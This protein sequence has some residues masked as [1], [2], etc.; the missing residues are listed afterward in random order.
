MRQRPTTSAFPT[1]LDTTLRRL[2]HYTLHPPTT[3]NN[4]AELTIMAAFSQPTQTII[5]ALAQLRQTIGPIVS[6]VLVLGVFVAAACSILLAA[7][8]YRST[9][10]ARITFPKVS[11]K[12]VEG[13]HV[14]LAPEKFPTTLPSGVP[15]V[16]LAGSIEMNV[17]A[18][19]QRW[20]TAQLLNTF[21]RESVA[22]FNPRRKHWEGSWEQ[23]MRNPEFAKQVNWELDAQEQVDVVAMYL[24]PGTKSPISL[25][26][27]GLFSDSGRL[28]VCCPDGFWRKGNVEV[29]CARHRIEM[30]ETFEDLVE[31]VNRRLSNKTSQT[32]LE[33]FDGHEA[34]PLEGGC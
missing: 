2:R 29:V 25:L 34:T 3:L 17:A 4:T 18:E 27:L 10:A 16:F 7:R 9:A 13:P 28:V 14:Y 8:A 1:T 11:D 22:V 33:D 32:Q 15:S 23:R 19:W 12:D 26:E 24:Q 21:G 6:R 5:S 30:V 31:A 20:M